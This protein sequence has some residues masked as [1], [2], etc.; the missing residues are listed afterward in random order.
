MN[1][2]YDH[3]K[4]FKFSPSFIVKLMLRYI[5]VS[6]END[7]IKISLKVHV[8]ISWNTFVAY[9]A[10]NAYFAECECFCCHQRQIKFVCIYIYI[11]HFYLV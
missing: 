8:I 9:L 5:H 7:G 11:C 6:C 10:L 1:N 4:T 2:V 3:A